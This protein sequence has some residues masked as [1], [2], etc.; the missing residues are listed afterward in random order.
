LALTSLCPRYRILA[1]IIHE[2]QLHQR[3][4]YNLEPV[5]ALLNWWTSLRLLDENTAYERSYALIPRGG[6]QRAERRGSQALA[7]RQ[8]STP[9][10]PIVSPRVPSEHSPMVTYSMLRN[11]FPLV[12][13]ETI[14]SLFP[15]E[16]Y[17]CQ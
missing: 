11:L 17:E 5:P 1:R 13:K 4:L 15:P 16:K 12:V 6:T 3:T 8:E 10:A 7:I 14:L 9:T 2:L